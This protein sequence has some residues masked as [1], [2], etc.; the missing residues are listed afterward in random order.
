VHHVL[1]RGER[2]IIYRIR[3]LVTVVLVEA[4]TGAT[5]KYTSNKKGFIL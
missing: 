2:G 4:L 5:S 1:H 3:W